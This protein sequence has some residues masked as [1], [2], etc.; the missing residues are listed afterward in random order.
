MQINQLIKLNNRDKTICKYSDIWS[1]LVKTEP[2]QKIGGLR[3]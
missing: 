1:N 2:P 3:T